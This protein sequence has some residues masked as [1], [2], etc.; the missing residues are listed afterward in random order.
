MSSNDRG[1]GKKNPECCQLIS[2]DIGGLYLSYRDELLVKGK[3]TGALK[4]SA[5]MAIPGERKHIG[6]EKILFMINIEN[7]HWALLVADV[8]K[9]RVEIC[10]SLSGYHAV[11]SE[12]SVTR[13]CA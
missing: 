8:Q 13:C 10:K 2:R 11:L 6:Y 5:N 12:Y 3:A 7:S 4:Y 1:E 9:R